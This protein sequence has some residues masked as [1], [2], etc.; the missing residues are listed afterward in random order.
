M[1]K[2]SMSDPSVKP[3]GT[4][5]ET[6]SKPCSLTVHPSANTQYP[7]LNAIYKNNCLLRNTDEELQT[8]V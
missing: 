5:N 8:F 3:C 4:A 2:L 1:Y 6:V 7:L